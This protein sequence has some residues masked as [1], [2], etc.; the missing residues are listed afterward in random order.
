MLH[1]NRRKDATTPLTT[2][3]IHHPGTRRPIRMTTI[4]H[5][6]N[7]SQSHLP[8][9]S[10]MRGGQASCTTEEGNRRRQAESH[11]IRDDQTQGRPLY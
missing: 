7:R 1:P 10:P 4:R 2:V 3:D 5:A 11:R 9:T 6:K 8:S